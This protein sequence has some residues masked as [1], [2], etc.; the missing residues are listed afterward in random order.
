VA[1]TGNSGREEDDRE[2]SRNDR[3]KNNE[4]KAGEFRFYR[5]SVFE[6]RYLDIIAIRSREKKPR[7]ATV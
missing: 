3:C 7:H 4:T 1:D 2:K 6:I 5:S